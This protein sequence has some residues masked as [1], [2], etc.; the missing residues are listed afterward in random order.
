MKIF[1]RLK[2]K[3]DP[4][5]D[6]LDVLTRESQRHYRAKQFNNLIK[7]GLAVMGV[8]F[9]AYNKNL[10]IT[11]HVAV[12]NIS[13]AITS[14]S[15]TGDG[16]ALASLLDQA[17]ESKKSKG[18][19]IRANSGGGSPVNAEAFWTRIT[20]INDQR[21]L[22]KK[23]L[24]FLSSHQFSENLGDQIRQAGLL[25]HIRAAQ[26]TLGLEALP[27]DNSGQLSDLQ[28]LKD[29]FKAKVEMEK[30]IVGVVGDLC[31]SA[32]YYMVSPIPQLYAARNSLVGNIGAKMAGFGFTGAM[33]KIGVERRVIASTDLKNLFDP[34]SESNSLVDQ[35][36]K[37]HLIGQTYEN[38]VSVVKSA[39]TGKLSADEKVFSGLVWVG[40]EALKLGLVD[41]IKSY[42]QVEKD[43]KEDLGVSS[44]KNYN[45]AGSASLLEKLT[46]EIGD[47]V[48]EM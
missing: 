10:F 46:G 20:E 12:I 22:D 29:H 21:A 5:S 15:K 24:E 39:R 25:P 2:F 44:I 14:G 33:E 38:F 42:Y 16:N 9:Y 36:V 3:P 27:F 4:P 41:G 6:M 23:S 40:S 13:G 7:L 31:A 18:V 8:V 26:K 48:L 32:C 47:F 1:R 35:H 28:A 11:D 43:L 17:L 30:P 34:Y 19:I 45:P 37:E